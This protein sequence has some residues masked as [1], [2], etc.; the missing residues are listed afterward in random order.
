MSSDELMM[1][2]CASCGTAEVDE[3]KLKTC[4]DCD[5]V[6]YCSVKCQQEHQS[7]HGEMCKERAAELRDEILFKQPERTHVGDCPI[8]F[9]PLP[10]DKQKSM[11][12]SCC[13]K[14]ICKGCVYADMIREK[15]RADYSCPFCRKMIPD[16]EREQYKDV[17]KRAAANDSF[18][19]ILLGVRCYSKGD[20]RGAF[21]HY[22]KAAD[23]GD[24]DAHY[25]LSLLYLMGEGVEKDEEKRAYHLEE[26]AIGGHP[27]ARYHLAAIEQQN[28]RVERKVKHLIIAANLGHSNSIQALKTC[29]KDGNVSKEEFAAAL[30]GHQA[31]LNAT[32]SPQ[33]EA[34][35]KA[36]AQF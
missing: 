19:M 13:S 21:K 1:R 30:R 33:R 27:E 20:F 22:E 23:L 4:D 12:N 28:G 29:Y 8:C 26:A 15:Q 25:H 14:I 2:F 7:Q 5:L 16:T 11:M 36:L 9:L 6:R 17:R 24:V 18:A 32:K 10:L 31:A 35:E 34:G 3:I